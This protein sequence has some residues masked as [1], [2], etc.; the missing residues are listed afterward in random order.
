MIGIMSTRGTD[1]TRHI[2][3]ER[4]R[5][6]TRKA[7]VHLRVKADQSPK[8]LAEDIQ[9]RG[10]LRTLWLVT[11][12]ENQSETRDETVNFHMVTH[13]R[14]ISIHNSGG[15]LQSTGC[16]THSKGWSHPADSL[17]MR[18][19]DTLDDKPDWN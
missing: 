2:E 16:D 14:S 11:L 15:H 12:N 8:H 3:W 4:C 18:Q 13:V 10:D 9:K 6:Q 17:E 5:R 19:E 1:S 7:S